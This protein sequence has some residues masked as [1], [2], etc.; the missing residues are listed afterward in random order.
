MKRAQTALQQLSDTEWLALAPK[1]WD[2][3]PQ[4]AYDWKMSADVEAKLRTLV[5]CEGL[6]FVDQGP[7]ERNQALRDRIA[8]RLASANVSELHQLSDWIV[9]DWGKIKQEPSF[10]WAEALLGF[11]P[12]TVEQFLSERGVDRISSWSKLLAF[13]D[14]DRYAIY[15]TRVAIALNIGLRA[16]GETRQFHLPDGR[17]VIVTR[18]ASALGKVK[19]PLGYLDYLSLLRAMVSE[20]GQTLLSAE[21]TLFAAAPHMAEKLMARMDDY[22]A[23]ACSMSC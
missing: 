21:T 12:A 17:N 2:V 15:D 9:R 11:A 16:I 5:P 18:A 4:V 1:L 10:A 19:R 20:R 6:S 3:L 8:P 7:L 14:S 13:A 23:E 22:L